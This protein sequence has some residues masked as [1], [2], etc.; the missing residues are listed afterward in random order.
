MT[1]ANHES[2]GVSFF[3]VSASDW[4]AM[5][6]LARQQVAGDGHVHPMQ[7]LRA[8]KFARAILDEHE[9][10]EQARS[11]MSDMAAVDVLKDVRE[12]ARGWEPDVRLLGNVRAE[13]I[14]NAVTVLL[15]NRQH[16]LDVIGDQNAELASLR[17]LVASMEE[18]RRGM[19]KALEEACDI[20]MRLAGL[21]CSTP[22]EERI[23]ELRKM[24][25]AG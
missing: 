18:G 9:K 19:G 4:P 5:V 6:R 24:A 23:A 22:D 25:E 7:A 3:D 8:D 14:A 11:S 16:L 1:S 10:R 13:S 17:A 20:G 12:C 2:E 15:C 21:E